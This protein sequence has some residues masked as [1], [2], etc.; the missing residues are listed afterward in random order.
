MSE[1]KKTILQYLR[2]KAGLFEAL[3]VDQIA[4]ELLIDRGEVYALLT[5]QTLKGCRA[6]D[7]ADY[8]IKKDEEDE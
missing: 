8:I 6:Q 7:V 2:A 4:N 1:K 3:S 5:T